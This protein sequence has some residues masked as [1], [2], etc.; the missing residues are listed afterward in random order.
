MQVAQGRP[1]SSSSAVSVMLA[2]VVAEQ[3]ALR[4]VELMCKTLADS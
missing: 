2:E 1:A 3:Q 4:Q